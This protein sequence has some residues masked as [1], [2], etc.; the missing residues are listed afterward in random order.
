MWS[1]VK[2]TPKLPWHVYS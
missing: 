1:G 2:S